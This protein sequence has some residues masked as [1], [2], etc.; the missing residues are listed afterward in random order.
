MLNYNFRTDPI[1]DVDA[2]VSGPNYRFT[3]IND[4]D[5]RFEWAE[6]GIFEDRSSTFAINRRLTRQNKLIVKETDPHL[7]I[8]TSTIHVSQLRF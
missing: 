2:L 4:F 6:D 1:P 7:E 8:I 5:L 3:I